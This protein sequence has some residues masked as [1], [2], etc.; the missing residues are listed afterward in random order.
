MPNEA[1]APPAFGR[2]PRAVKG[3]GRKLMPPI[4]GFVV[5]AAACAALAGP[6]FAARV[7]LDRSTAHRVI[8]VIKRD[9]RRGAMPGAIVGIERDGQPPW[10]VARGVANLLTGTRMQANSHVRIGSVTK[11]FVTTLLLRLVQERRLS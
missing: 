1:Q 9:M 4:F 3:P 8:A 5:V 2:Y 7:P 11:A 10:I 6:A